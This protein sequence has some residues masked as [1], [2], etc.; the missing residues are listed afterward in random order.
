[1]ETITL[2]DPNTP[3][4]RLVLTLETHPDSSFNSGTWAGSHG[5]GEV[6]SAGVNTIPTSATGIFDMF[7]ISTDS[8]SGHSGQDGFSIV[9]ISPRSANYLHSTPRAVLLKKSN[10]LLNFVYF[11]LSPLID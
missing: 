6:A 3:Y 9:F 5:F 1:M 11:L 7:F 8:S 4:T 10:A 2:T